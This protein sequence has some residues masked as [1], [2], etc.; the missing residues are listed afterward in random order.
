MPF[1]TC[2]EKV[3]YTAKVQRKDFL[4]SGLYPVV[5]Q[6]VGL[7]NGYWNQVCDIFSLKRPVVIFGDHTKILKYVDFDFVLGADGVKILQPKD[8]LDPRFF[9][10]QLQIA[11]LDSLGYARHYKLLKELEIKFPTLLEQQ[12]IVAILDEAFEGIATAVANAEQNLI[13]A[14]EVFE[15]YLNSVFVNKGD[16]WL[17]STI[18]VIGK[19]FDGPHATPKTV[20][21]G[22][23]F[24]G[25][26]SLESGRINL[27][28]TRH[29]NAQ[30]F[31]TWTRR[32]KPQS[33]DI[34]FS[35]ETRLGQIAIIPEGMECC[36][37]RRMGLV[38][39]NKAKI[40][41][42]F[43]VYQYLSP[44]YKAFL[45]S[46]TVKGATVDRI[47]LKD[48][49]NFQFSLPSLKEQQRISSAI[50]TIA[51]ET[52]RLESIYQQKLSA[53]DELKK[54]ILH[55]AFSGQL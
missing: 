11:N 13:N 51:S 8:F 15:S 48:F 6:E 54:S 17:D 16:G 47:P 3:T 7:V 18:G 29:V 45:A 37:G 52:Q 22:P 39:P 35:Y 55:Q 31:I 26:S 30:D 43:F 38:R 40:D 1:E 19:V 32:V 33:D 46:K 42:K 20:D 44:P 14:R 28:E 41:P 21:R 5:S 4:D 2:I 53:L 50:N 24:L 23:I 27:G 12:R 9:F 34:V 49:P 36:L 10:Y 25:I